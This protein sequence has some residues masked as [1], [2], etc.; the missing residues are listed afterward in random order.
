MNNNR[1]TFIRNKENI[2]PLQNLK[3]L[4]KETKKYS[5]KNKKI[6]L[7]YNSSIRNFSSIKENPQK[8]KEYQNNIMNHLKNQE[9]RYVINSNYMENQNDINSKMLLK[10]QTSKIFLRIRLI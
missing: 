9:I 3:K 5:G 6:P 10:R 7:L 1:K 4:K 2:Q 8:V